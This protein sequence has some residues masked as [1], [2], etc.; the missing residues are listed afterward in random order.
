MKHLAR[1]APEGDTY[2]V[3][4][5]GGGTAVLEGWRPATIDVDLYSS[6][7]RV[8]GDIQRLKERLGLNVE[9]VRPEDFVPALTGTEDRHV[10][11]ETIGRVSFY[12]YDPCAQLLSKI[13]RG[14]DKDLEDGR[15]LVVSGMVEPERFRALVEA[16]PDEAFAR[17]PS[18]SPRAVRRAVSAFLGQLEPRED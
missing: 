3:H 18:L 16:I 2:R 17:Y 8:F 5:V 14:F 4:L 15:R 11:I 10:F 1:G 7:E 13:V 6:S 9:F 12:H